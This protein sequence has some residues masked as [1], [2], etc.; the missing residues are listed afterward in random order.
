MYTAVFFTVLRIYGKITPKTNFGGI[1]LKISVKTQE[2]WTQTDTLWSALFIGGQ[3]KTD[4][5]QA[6]HTPVLSFTGGGGKTSYIRRLA[7]EGREKGYHVLVMTTTH[8]AAPKH[9]GVLEPDREK[10]KKMLEKE[11]I[12]VAGRPA[13]EGKIAFWDWDFYEKAV[14]LADVVLVEADGSKRLPVKVPGPGEPVIPG[15]SDL[16]LCIYGLGALGKQADGCCFRMQPSEQLL[17]IP[18]DQ[19][20]GNWIMTEEKM[21]LLMKKGYLEP[22]RRQFPDS[23]VLPA[24]NQADTVKLKKNGKNILEKMQEE[25]GILTGELWKETSFNLF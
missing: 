23:R 11:G 10:I 14:K 13:K 12:A 9:F 24:F 1:Y 5:V 4:T 3:L 18:E 20:D 16:I 19:K 15:N 25:Q 8:M 7:W 22:L 6:D 17:K 21:A 2:N